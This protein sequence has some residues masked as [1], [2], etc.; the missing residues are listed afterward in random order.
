MTLV[1]SLFPPS[2]TVPLCRVQGYSRLSS[3]HRVHTRVLSNIA[4]EVEEA[5]VLEPVMIVKDAVA[6]L[7]RFGV[8]PPLLGVLDAALEEAVNLVRDARNVRRQRLL[9]E[10][11][12]L[13]RASGGITDGTGGAADLESATKG[14]QIAYQSESMVTTG[15]EVQ[16]AQEGKEVTDVQ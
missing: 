2:R 7:R 14:V 12:A 11:I 9:V 5:H 15:A 1:V 3:E 6:L 13:R 4:K 8:V 10:G 16:Q